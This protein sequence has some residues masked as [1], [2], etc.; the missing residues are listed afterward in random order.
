MLRTPSACGV[1]AI[2]IGIAL[3]AVTAFAADESLPKLREEKLAAAK[4]MYLAVE[5]GCEA[6][7]NPVTEVY[8]ASK[9]WKDASY[10]LAKTKTQRVAALEQHRDRMEKLYKTI[11][12]L[13]IAN[14][15]G[16]ELDKEAAARFWVAQAKTW[17]AEEE[18]KP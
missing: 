15:K 10:E 14:Q 9:G 2:W 18:A 1:F 16:G 11:H 8:S 3:F 5:V 7:V 4:E 6:G 13:A 12:K 17:L